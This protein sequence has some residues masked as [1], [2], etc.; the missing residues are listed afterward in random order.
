MTQPQYVVKINGQRY[1]TDWVFYGGPQ[2]SRD[3][4][5]ARKFSHSEAVY[6]MHRINALHVYRAELEE[7]KETHG[8]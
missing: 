1:F 7:V 5:K 6:W 8:K 2:A 4:A 3:V